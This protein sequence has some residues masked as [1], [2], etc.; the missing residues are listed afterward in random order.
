VLIDRQHTCE[1]P[2]MRLWAEAS[3]ISCFWLVRNEQS[4]SS[5]VVAVF[6]EAST[7]TSVIIADGVVLKTSRPSIMR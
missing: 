4:M 5:A 7:I 6:L 2:N 3:M 1:V